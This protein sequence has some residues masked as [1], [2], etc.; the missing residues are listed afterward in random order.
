MNISIVITEWKRWCP[1]GY[2]V[3][4]TLWDTYEFEP[5]SVTERFFLTKSKARKWAVVAKTVLEYMF[6]DIQSEKVG[7]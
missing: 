5:I 3:S 1:V 7:A 2:R 6:K 4:A